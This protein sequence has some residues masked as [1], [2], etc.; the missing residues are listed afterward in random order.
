MLVGL[1][2]LLIAGATA[3]AE[4]S[5]EERPGKFCSARLSDEQKLFTPAGPALTRR[6]VSAVAASL[7]LGGHPRAHASAAA[8]KRAARRQKRH[9]VAAARLRRALRKAKPPVSVDSRAEPLASPAQLN[10]PFEDGRETLV[11]HQVFKAPTGVP[12]GLMQVSAPF[13][14]VS[15][16]DGNVV[17]YTQLAGRITRRGPGALFTVAVCINPAGPTELQPGTYSGAVLVGARNLLSPVTVQATVQD[18][19]WWRVALAAL[20]GG[21]AGLFVKLYG[22]MRVLGG[23]RRQHILSA[24]FA[25][26]LGAAGVTAVYSYLT[27]YVDDPT[28]VASGDNLWRVTAEVFAGT[29]AAKAL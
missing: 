18:D 4:S 9:K 16:A 11:R 27:I 3:L 29:L 7:R 19:R 17:P 22:D 2:V 15:D 5:T 24:K 26:A 23:R 28:F 8:R 21:L 6:P 25:F 13:G 12:V 10:F 1:V 14:D 20:I